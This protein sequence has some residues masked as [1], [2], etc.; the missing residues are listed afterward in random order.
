MDID[1]NPLPDQTSRSE[2]IA[3]EPSKQQLLSTERIFSPSDLSSTP[4]MKSGL[5]INAIRD[6]ALSYGTKAGLYFKAEQ[7][8]QLIAKKYQASLDVISF[9]P[10]MQ[11]TNLLMPSIDITQFSEV[12][13]DGVLSNVRESYT[14]DAP[15]KLVTTAP[16]FRDYL[17]L[18]F[19]QPSQIHSVLKPTTNGEEAVWTEYVNEGWML[20]VNQAEDIF[21]DGLNRF[22]KDTL[23]RINYRQ[24][25]SLGIV[26]PPI[27][28][29]NSFIQTFN[30]D[31]MHIGEVQ[32]RIVKPVAFTSIKKQDLPLD[33]PLFEKQLEKPEP[34]NSVDRHSSGVEVVKLNQ[35][36]RALGKVV[37]SQ[38]TGKTNPDTALNGWMVQ[39]GTFSIK[40]NAIALKDKII[41]AG[42]DGH[43]I[44]REHFSIVVVG[45]EANKSKAYILQKKLNAQFE[46]TSIVIF[47]NQNSDSKK[48]H[49]Q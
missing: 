33:E 46:G 24:A 19:E 17:I 35:D 13:R 26:S 29:R 10:L 41:K 39:L 4:S 22:V 9:R 42:L 25:L 12:L 2:Y 43:I 48:D 3:V 38:P 15:S 11:G 5:R 28:G 32:L 23:G 18:G 27:V 14:I 6:A 40:A 37:T 16:T 30:E 1:T 36:T 7:I 31:T 47:Y 8:N 21:Q 20:G 45:P 34:A 49:Q 44:N